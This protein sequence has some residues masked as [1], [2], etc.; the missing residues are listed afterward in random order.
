MLLEGRLRSRV[1]SV[2]EPEDLLTRGLDGQR[3]ATLA[4]DVGGGWISAGP[5][6]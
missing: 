5:G 2:R 1:D 6:V 3:H 4:F